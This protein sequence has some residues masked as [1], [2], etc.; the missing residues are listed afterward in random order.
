GEVRRLKAKVS[1]VGQAGPPKPQGEVS[2]VSF[3]DIKDDVEISVNATTDQPVILIRTGKQGFAIR[4]LPRKEGPGIDVRCS[5]LYADPDKRHTIG[6]AL[7]EGEEWEVSGAVQVEFGPDVN[8][9]QRL[10]IKLPPPHT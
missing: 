10:I 1:Q 9:I 6:H 4:P 3:E 5:V 8:G 2:S 7:L